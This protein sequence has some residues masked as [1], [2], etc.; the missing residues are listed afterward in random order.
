MNPAEQANPGPHDTEHEVAAYLAEHRDFF[1]THQELLASLELHH[2][3][4]RAVSLI[5]RQVQ[6]LRL[7]QQRVERKLQ[8]L[9]ARANE[10][11]RLG[12]KL[13][14][15]ALD[16]LD[17]TTLEATAHCIHDHLVRSFTADGVALQL[18][19]DR[20]T[21]P[22][23]DG[24]CWL[25]SGQPELAEFDNILG[26]HAPICGRLTARQLAGLFGSASPSIGSAVVIPLA[27]DATFGLLA[28]GSH[29]PDRYQHGMGTTF[30]VLLGR[31]VARALVRHL[32]LARPARASDEAE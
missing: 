28:I 11:D 20:V 7:Q 18:F 12:E 14:E 27:G 29:D 22:A 9:L 17:C 19:D 16:L 2:T 32:A 23:A 15:L 8:E 4:G 3:S 26:S 31:L 25:A 30:L 24:V 6:A 1:D 5:E 21:G 13:H 10:N